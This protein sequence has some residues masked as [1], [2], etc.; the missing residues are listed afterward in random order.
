MRFRACGLGFRVK[1][2]ET[3]A[4]EDVEVGVVELLGVRVHELRGVVREHANLS[5]Q[6]S[7]FRVQG[8]GAG[9]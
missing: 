4:L 5:G 6:V 9:V 7:G 2:L 8:P 1:G 3:L